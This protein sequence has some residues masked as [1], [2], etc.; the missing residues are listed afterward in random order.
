ME[1]IQGENLYDYLQRRQFEP[2]SEPA[3]LR[4]LR[5]LVEILDLVH[6]ANY[7]HRDIKPP[8]IMLRQ[9]GQLA[10]IDFGT[11]R[12][13]TE[14]YFQKQQGKQVTGIAWVFTFFGVAG[15]LVSLSWCF[16]SGVCHPLDYI[17]SIGFWL[18]S[19]FFVNLCMIC[20]NLRKTKRLYFWGYYFIL[21]IPNFLVN[22][23]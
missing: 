21:G 12:E 22:F 15:Y 9:N 20:G 17:F 16:A 18:L 23:V 5:Q 6:G 2:I 7:F 11:A 4:W 10:L 3:A 8:N 14:T 13:E 1:Y 19:I